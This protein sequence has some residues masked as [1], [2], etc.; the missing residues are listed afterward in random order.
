[1]NISV[2]SR[3]IG[4]ALVFNAVFMF[5][6]AITSMIYDFDPAFS[7][8]F[9]SA[10][11]TFTTGLFPLIFVRKYE[12]INI[13]EGFTIIVFSWVLS[14][15]F[16]ML[17]YV[18]WGGE[19]SLINAWYESVSGYTTTGATILTDIESLPKGLLFWRSSTHFLGGIG[20]VIFM[21]LILPSVSTFKMRLSKME[22]STL[23][24]ENYKFKTQQTIRVIASVYVGLTVLETICLMLV[25]MDFFD[26]INHSFSTVSTGGFSTKNLSIKS[27]H[28]YPIELV[29]TI[30]MLLSGL[31]FG[32]LYSSLVSRSGKIFRSPITKFFLITVL[33]A[34][35]LMAVDLI[36]S[37]VV[38]NWV[39]ALRQSV[40]QAVSIASTTGFATTDTTLWPNFS[41]LILLYLSIQCACSGSTTGGIK[42]DRVY[43][44]WKSV[45][46]QIKKQ[47]HPNAVIP[48]RIGNHTI[49][50][51]MIAAV[52]LFIALYIFIV[53]VVG[54][55]LSAMGIDMLEAFSASV[56]NMGNV[57][58]AFGTAG[59]LGNYHDFP[60]MAK[61]ILSI[62][63]LLGR[64]EIYSML[65]LFVIYKWR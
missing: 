16:G 37:G 22:I 4:I 59:S 40:F 63:M 11:I 26:A 41:I 47:V 35:L 56:A 24:K 8:L 44:W 65:V 54:V 17:P 31:H 15:V 57:G 45:R 28:S 12:E 52:N 49:E 3:N 6:G 25:G 64:V 53:F 32:L 62:E 9:L 34:T 1:M 5:L 14:C 43:L 18:L 7:P 2:V 30:F 50:P 33:I 58:P 29:I 36:W 42:S 55:L 38:S 19:F 39:Q 21:L 60:V 46:T 48:V 20:V 51:D 10:V 23:S 27:F 13:K 61:F